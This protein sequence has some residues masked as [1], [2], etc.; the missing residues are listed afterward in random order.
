MTNSDLE[1]PSGSPESSNSP[2]MDREL[3]EVVSS[4]EEIQTELHYRQ[5]QDALKELVLTLDLTPQERAGLE[6]EIRNLTALLEKLEQLVVQIAVFGMVGRG[7]SSLLNALLGEDIFE[8]GPTHGVTRAVQSARWSVSPTLNPG[9]DCTAP[10]VR[11]V[12]LHGLHNSQIELIDTP[13]IDE[14]NGEQRERLARQIAQQ[15]DLIL[16]V[17]SG[18]ITKVEYAALSS[19]RE[20]S[21]PILLVFNKIDQYPDTDRQAIYQKIRDERVKEILSPEEIVMA[22]AS[23]LV[24]RA[25]RSAEGKI[26]AQLSRGEPQVTDLKLK[27]LEVLDREG[28]SLVALNTMLYADDVNEQILQRKLLIRER[29]A[30]QVIWNAVMTKSTAIALNPFTVVDILTGAVI[31]VVQVLTLSRLYGIPMN[32]QGAVNL[33]QKIALSMGGISASELLANLGLSSLKGLLGLSAPA[34][35]GITLAPY[36]AVAVTQAGV[37]GVSSYAIGQIAKAYLVNGASWGP[38]GPKAVVMKILSSLD[39]TSILM[40]IKDELAARLDLSAQ[41]RSTDSRES[42]WSNGKTSS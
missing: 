20:V 16:F 25:V 37:A 22:A 15:A 2:E 34:T 7:K 32:H 41:R 35:G 8:V 39:E 33:L 19:L 42:G 12:V 31:D 11:R 27:I 30:N 36:M 10:Q 9:G 3:A 18:D 1:F 17:I 4:F 6:P 40:R 29:S 28:K 23:P 13:G 24:A 5:A 14:V 26:S 21:K 38:D